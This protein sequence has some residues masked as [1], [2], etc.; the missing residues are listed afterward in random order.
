MCEVI[1]SCVTNVH[2]PWSRVLLEKLTNQ[3][4][5]SQEIPSILWNPKVYYHIYKCPPSVLFL[6]QLDPDHTPTSNFLKIHL[7]IILPSMPGSPKWSLSLRFPQQNPVYASLL[8]HMCY[9]PHPSNSSPFY[10]PNN[11]G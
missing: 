6:S 9:M 8:L 7:K 4:S 2:T 1:G 3:F 5:A 11:T 10:H